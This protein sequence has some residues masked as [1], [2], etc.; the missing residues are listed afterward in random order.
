MTVME[1]GLWARAAAGAAANAIRANAASRSGRER[2]VH[3]QIS[4]SRLPCAVDRDYRK[5]DGR[6]QGSKRVGNP[7]VHDDRRAGIPVE[8]ALTSGEMAIVGRSKTL[9]HDGS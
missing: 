6:L 3:I 2:R 8:I 1:R 5:G 4:F 9:H 7:E